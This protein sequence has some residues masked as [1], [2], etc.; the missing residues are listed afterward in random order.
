MNVNENVFELTTEEF[1]HYVYDPYTY[2]LI[3]R[4]MS[5]LILFYNISCR[6]C[7]KFVPTW[8][9]F[10]GNYNHVLRIG[11]VDCS[12]EDN[13]EICLQFKIESYPTI[14]YFKDDKYHRLS[15]NRAFSKLE[16]FV[17]KLG[18]LDTNDQGR[19][20]HKLP[21]FKKKVSYEKIQELKK[22]KLYVNEPKK[23]KTYL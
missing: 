11:Q 20:P 18:Y 4:R 5:W 2:Q 8:N 22:D 1:E 19:I 7:Q 9:E 15:G 16:N 21:N 23:V 17:F 10:A 12:N 13:H 14:M 6:P 3:D